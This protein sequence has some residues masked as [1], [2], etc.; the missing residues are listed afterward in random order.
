[1]R[2]ATE[3]LTFRGRELSLS[4]QHPLEP[5]LLKLPARPDFRLQ[6]TVDV[7]YVA[8]WEV[9][10]DDTLWLTSLQTRPDDAGP[11]P[12]M[13][14]LFPNVAAV[15][16]TWLSQTLRATEAFHK[17]FSP[18]GNGTV[19]ARETHLSFWQGL[20]IATEETEVQTGRRVAG[21][22]SPHLERLYGL[23]EAAFLRAAFAAPEDAAP[24][25]IY[26]DWLEERGDPRA[27]LIRMADRLRN[28]RPEAAKWERASFRDRLAQLHSPSLPLWLRLLGLWE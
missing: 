11:D 8:A 21:E 16:A 14:L 2:L 25:L 17:R 27:E 9:R 28:L 23:E 15:A 26:A 20:L 22:L 5:Y 18:V 19:Y 3:R 6:R 10:T 13:R 7:G 24:R 12:G 1:M 4:G